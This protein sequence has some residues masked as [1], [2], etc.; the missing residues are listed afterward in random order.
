M[1]VEVHPGKA[2]PRD[3][4]PDPAELRDWKPVAE[5]VRPAELLDNLYG[6]YSPFPT[7]MLGANLAGKCPILG[8]REITNLSSL[9]RSY[10]TSI[11]LT[12]TSVSLERNRD[13]GSADF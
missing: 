13:S 10:L 11:A 8:Y 1:P 5:T 3:R 12:R 4:C 7:L 6:I 2:P 9:D